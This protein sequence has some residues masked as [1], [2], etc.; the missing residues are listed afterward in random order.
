ME[1]IAAIQFGNQ[2][3]RRNPAYHLID[4][5]YSNPYFLWV[6]PVNSSASPNVDDPILE[7]Y[8]FSNTTAQFWIGLPDG[9]YSITLTCFEPS[10]NHGPFSVKA[11]S[12]TVVDPISVTAGIVTTKTFECEA[13]DGI[14]KLEFTPND[15]KDFVINSLVVEGNRQA[16]LH[17]VFKSAPPVVMPSKQ[18]LA[19]HAEHEPR[20]ALRDLCDWLADH[21]DENGFIGDKWNDTRGMMHPYWYTASMPVR[22]LLAGYEIIHNQQYLDVC[23]EVMDSFISEQLPNG[24]WTDTYRN[25]PTASL[26]NNET[27]WIMST[28]RQ[29]M[30]DI[31]S[32]VQ[33]LAM[34][35]HY[36]PASKKQDYVQAVRHFCDDWATR[37]QMPS[38]AFSDG[39]GLGDGVYSCATAIEAAVFS[40]AYDLTGDSGY[41]SVAEKAIRYLLEDWQDNG[42]MIGRGPHWKVRSGKP[43]LLETLYFGD[44]WYYDDGFITTCCHSE[45]VELRSKINKALENRVFGSSGLLQALNGEVWWPVQDIWNNAKSIGMVQTLIYMETCG[46]SN[47]LL[48]EALETMQQLLCTHEYSRRL[49]VMPDD[50]ERPS[51]IYSLQTWSGMSMEATGFAAMTLAEMI[52][53]GILYLRS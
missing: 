12:T 30:S 41:M 5:V 42:R 21:R 31:G 19:A 22:A 26:S 9:T 50:K 27:E 51:S 24:A 44:Q 11:N 39:V 34:A 15:G 32:V 1:T 16:A 46:M 14:L 20:K 35:C 28:R 37:F 6:S 43:F 38:G 45:N 53:P 3:Q 49:G 18:E 29:P 4:R 13:G 52:K 10:K 47:P 48:D 23:M 17:P 25:Q 33:S 2:Y 8:V 40:L 36:A 7:G